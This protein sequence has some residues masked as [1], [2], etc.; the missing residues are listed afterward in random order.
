MHKPS[1]KLRMFPTLFLGEVTHCRMFSRGDCHAIRPGHGL[2]Q[3][4]LSSNP[5]VLTHH[6]YSQSPPSLITHV[7]PRRTIRQPVPGTANPNRRRGLSVA[8]RISQAQDIETRLRELGE[9]PEVI[10]EV[11]SPLRKRRF[12]DI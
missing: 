10:R 9:A 8:Q 3:L 1:S 5:E 7:D 6:P 11:V 2:D 4:N 12:D